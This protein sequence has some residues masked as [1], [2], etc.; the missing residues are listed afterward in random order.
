M[1]AWETTGTTH[2]LYCTCLDSVC[3]PNVSDCMFGEECP[4]SSSDQDTMVK[5]SSNLSSWLVGMV[6][7]LSVGDFVA[8][9]LLPCCSAILLPPDHALW[10]SIEAKYK[11]MFSLGKLAFHIITQCLCSAKQEILSTTNTRRS[12]EVPRHDPLK[13]RCR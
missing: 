5:A 9:G 12:T 4:A 3:L 11:C 6:R 13:A 2:A 7:G 1:Q 8:F 10:G